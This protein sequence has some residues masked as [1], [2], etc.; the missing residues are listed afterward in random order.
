MNSCR[1]YYSSNGCKMFGKDATVWYRLVGLLGILTL[2]DTFGL[3]AADAAE[4]ATVTIAPAFSAEPTDAE[5][6]RARMFQEPLVPTGKTSVAEN[7]ALASALEAFWRRTNPEDVS[8]L[9]TFLDLYP[10]S[11]WR[12]GLQLNLGFEYY[13]TARYSKCLTAWEDAWNASKNAREAKACAM[14]DLALSA[15]LKV[16]KPRWRAAFGII[17]PDR[18]TRAAPLH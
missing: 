2:A 7:Q 9:T 8:T 17:S 5:I 6:M 15:F 14:A 4:S 1:I 3:N 16:K 12:G 10:S 18:K 11:P 13:H